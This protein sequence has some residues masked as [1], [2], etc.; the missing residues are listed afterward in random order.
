MAAKDGIN[1]STQP[2]E[3]C[4]KALCDKKNCSSEEK[5]VC[6]S[7]FLTYTNLCYF[8]AERC[9]DDKISILFY[10]QLHTFHA[11]IVAKLY[12]YT[13]EKLDS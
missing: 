11:C 2:E 4:L 7:N 8:N 1:L 6:G 10:G 5:P 9:K 12:D 13:C 3:Y